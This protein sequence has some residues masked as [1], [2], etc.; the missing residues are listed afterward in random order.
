MS[1]RYP[2]GDATLRHEAL[3]GRPFGPVADEQQQEIIEGVAKS[4]EGLDQKRQAVPGVEAANEADHPTARQG[5]AVDP[6]QRRHLRGKTVWIGGVGEDDDSAWIN[7]VSMGQL[8][9]Q[10][11]GYRQQPVGAPEEPGIDADG[12]ARSRATTTAAGS[13]A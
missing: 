1:R 6:I 5:M 9:A 11:A 7:P 13:S 4:G 10:C 3:D 8:V 12:R 2:V